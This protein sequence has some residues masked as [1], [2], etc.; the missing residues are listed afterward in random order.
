MKA[1]ILI[2]KEYQTDIYEQLHNTIK[3]YF[4]QKKFELDEIK[5]GKEDLAFCMG[6][7]GC[8]VKK[9]GE[10][11]IDDTMSQIN[12]KFINSD[13]VICLSP[14]VFGQF[15]AN[16]KNALDRWLPNVLPFFITRPDGSTMHPS[17][18]KSY[19]RQIVIAYAE[20]IK[21]E[22]AEL[23]VDIVKKHRRSMDVIVYKNSQAK[24]L[25][26]LNNIDMMRVGDEL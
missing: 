15:S 26:S 24:L 11:V 22:D 9:P 25:E 10:C 1:L 19:P 3:D 23:V 2:D 17:R 6:C 13:V 7:F 20:D 5:I 21:D 16:I 12:H 8:W 14:L 18:Y 4:E